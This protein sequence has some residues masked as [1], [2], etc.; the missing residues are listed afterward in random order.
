MTLCA[1]PAAHPALHCCARF[2]GSRLAAG[3][4]APEV[5]V[6]GVPGHLHAVGGHRAHGDAVRLHLPVHAE[7]R[8]E[9]AVPRR[10]P[11]RP[12]AVPPRRAAQP[13]EVQRPGRHV[14]LVWDGSSCFSGFGAMYL[15]GLM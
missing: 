2:T 8:R 12:G 10:V 4:A 6:P 3:V 15:V 14:N 9:P 7:V 11:R 13:E 1:L 5:Q